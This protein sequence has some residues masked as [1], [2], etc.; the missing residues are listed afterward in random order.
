MVMLA[1]KGVMPRNKPSTPL[2]HYFGVYSHTN[3][4][5]TEI[6]LK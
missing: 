3:R 2:T 6:D 4:K 1:L 5:V